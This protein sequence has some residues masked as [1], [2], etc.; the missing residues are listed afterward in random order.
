[1]MPHPVMEPSERSCFGRGVTFFSSQSAMTGARCVQS[2]TTTG[3]AIEQETEY[4][5]RRKRTS[6]V[7]DRGGEDPV[8][9]EALAP[10][11]QPSQCLAAVLSA[12]L[13]ERCAMNQ[14]S[15]FAPNLNRRVS[16]A[17]QRA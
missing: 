15:C 3:T 4:G 12:S 8:H 14:I 10:V 6:L 17:R 1:M 2:A 13:V 7:D 9:P 5:L 16:D 11:L